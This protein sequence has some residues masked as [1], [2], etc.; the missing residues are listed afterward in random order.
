MELEV[1]SDQLYHLS[2]AVCGLRRTVKQALADLDS[3]LS[4]ISDVESVK[5]SQEELKVWHLL[6]HLLQCS[7]C[8]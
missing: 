7:F 8:D 6:V 2:D 1:V 5:A 3:M 4:V